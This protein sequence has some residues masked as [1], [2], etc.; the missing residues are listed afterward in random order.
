MKLIKAL[1]FIIPISLNSKLN[2]NL[3]FAEY[4]Q[5]SQFF[6]K[7]VN[8]LNWQIVESNFE[9]LRKQTVK[10]KTKI[11]KKIHQIWLGSPL[12]KKYYKLTGS[13]KKFH[14]D[15][16]YKLWTDKDIESFGLYNKKL[17]DSTTNYGEKSDI[18]RYEILNRYGGL[19][20]DTDFEC[21][22]PFDELNEYCD[23]YAGL[24]Y[25]TEPVL[26]CGLI[27]AISN[28]P[29]LKACIEAM[30]RKNDKEDFKSI[31][32]RSSVFHFTKCFFKNYTQN[33]IAFP[34]SFFYPLPDTKKDTQN[35]NQFLKP[36]SYAIHYWHL[37]W[38]NG[39]IG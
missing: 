37:S 10:I 2:L 3:S 30:H 32:Q 14:P 38:N 25:S 33:S 20:V 36:E 29:I 21:L 24:G 5:S 15:W 35:I 31:L 13:W 26:L 1:F 27:G 28:H 4:M 19:Y 12:P 9:N 23:F 17:Y 6:F 22:K 16:E 18:L 11:P 7:N 34:V 8:C 39:K